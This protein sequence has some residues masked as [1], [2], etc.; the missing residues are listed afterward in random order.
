MVANLALHEKNSEVS[1]FNIFIDAFK[2]V[3]KIE[4]NLK[5]LEQF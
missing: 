4:G 5:K 1:P 2:E 3:S